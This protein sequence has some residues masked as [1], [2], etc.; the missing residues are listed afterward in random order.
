MKKTFLPIP[1]QY[2]NADFFL[3][4]IRKTIEKKEEKPMVKTSILFDGKQI[5][6]T[7]MEISSIEKPWIKLILEDGTALRISVLIQKVI[8]LD[9]KTDNEGK[10]LY[11]IINQVA[12]TL[13]DDDPTMN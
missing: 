3:D 11:A 4:M 8:R 7:S 9:G 10:Q 12:C 5:P 2:V 1:T 13:I 6:A